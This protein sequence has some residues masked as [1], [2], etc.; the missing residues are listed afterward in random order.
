M[1]PTDGD[2]GDTSLTC[3][4]KMIGDGVEAM[5]GTIAAVLLIPTI[6]DNIHFLCTSSMMLMVHLLLD[7]CTDRRHPCSSTALRGWQASQ[8]RTEKVV[9]RLATE[10]IGVVMVTEVGGV[11]GVES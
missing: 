5:E 7:V 4:E 10:V 6:G 11:G 2:D 3:D 1:E 8:R 9:L